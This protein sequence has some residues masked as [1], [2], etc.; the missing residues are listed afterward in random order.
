[1]RLHPI[2]QKAKKVFK[3]KKILN[4]QVNCNSF[5]PDWRK[6]N[7]SKIYSSNKNKGGGV[8]LDLSHEID[9]ILW[10]F[11]K[12]KIKHFI[13]NKISKLKI[14]SEDFASLSGSVLDKGNLQLSLSYFSRINRR[15][16]SVDSD[17][18]SFYGDLV[19]NYFKLKNNKKEME[20]NFQ[21]NQVDLLYNVHKKIIKGKFKDLCTLQEG[22][23]VLKL[24]EKLKKN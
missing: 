13:I 2:I 4:L 8:L 15:S 22:I 16:I 20:R 3:N 19:K 14:D 12:I 24:I 23:K 1:M 17:K 21:V 10:I 6:R 7:Y 5:L 9:Y 11:D 18:E